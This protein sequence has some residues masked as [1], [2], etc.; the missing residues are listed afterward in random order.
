MVTI[1]NS[2]IADSPSGGNCA[3]SGTFTAQGTNF[4][5]DGSCTGF[6]QVTSA[7]L[8][9]GPLANNGGPTQTHALGSGSVAIDAVTDC[10]LPDGTTQVTTDQRGVARPQ[11][12]TD[13]AKC[14]VGSYEAECS[15]TPT[16]TTSAPTATPTPLASSPTPTPSAPPPTPTE[17]PTPTL[18]PSATL[19]QTPTTTST[20]TYTRTPTRTPTITPTFSDSENGAGAFACSDNFDNDNDGRVDCADPD[21]TQDP[22][23]SAPVPV[24]GT[25]GNWFL[26]AILGLLGLFS[27]LRWR[28]LFRA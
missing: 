9:L 12:C 6:T 15:A 11:A 23:C 10:T 21:C 24:T 28:A 5:T 17:T 14:D 7:A 16:P 18:T 13:E 8:N 2:I 3:N 26:A 20:P 25:S 22:R 27:L 19:T 4:A 1:K